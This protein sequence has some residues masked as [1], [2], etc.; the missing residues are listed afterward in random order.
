MAIDK[1]FAVCHVCMRPALQGACLEAHCGLRND[2]CPTHTP[3]CQE[4]R[5]HVHTSVTCVLCGAEGA[6]AEAWCPMPGGRGHAEASRMVNTQA[7][8]T[9]IVDSGLYD[10]IM[11]AEAR[12][13]PRLQR[14][15][16]EPGF[17]CGPVLRDPAD[18][19]ET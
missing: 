18:D 3:G 14:L 12:D 9:K 6:C 7:F 17:F 13:L 5:P 15:M 4:L 2:A 16:R 1:G 8:W 10:A 19:R 11:H